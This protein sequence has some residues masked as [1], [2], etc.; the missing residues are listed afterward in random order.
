ML[1]CASLQIPVWVYGVVSLGVTMREKPVFVH[2]GSLY[3]IVSEPVPYP[4][5]RG[6]KPLGLFLLFG[7]VL[8]RYLIWLGIWPQVNGTHAN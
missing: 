7:A 6:F 8:K 2:D 5:N 4:V 3:G 1:P